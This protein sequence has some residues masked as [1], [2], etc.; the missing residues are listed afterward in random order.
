MT[1]C[2]FCKIVAGEIPSKKVYDEGKCLAFL[3]INPRNPGHTLVIT[4]KHVQDIFSIGEESGELMKAIRKVA[5]G[6]RKATGAKGIT[7]TQSN[8]QMAGQAVP[9]IHFHIIP[10]T[11]AEKGIGLEGVLPV[12]QQDE[13]SLNAMAG[14]ISKA[15]PTAEGKPAPIMEESKEPKKEEPGGKP[16]GKERDPERQDINFDF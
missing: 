10:R 2:I 15:I 9:H 4:K 16:V 11:E 13:A 3:D 14:K 1:D 7:I 6:V 8:G 5:I 12:K